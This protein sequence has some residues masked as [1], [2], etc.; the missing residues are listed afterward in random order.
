MLEDRLIE[1]DEELRAIGDV[2]ATGRSGSGAVVSIAGPAGIGKTRLLNAL[3]A[4]AVAGGFRVHRARAAELE[5]DLSRV[6]ISR[7]PVS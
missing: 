1:R 7:T 5:S 4:R 6:K 2:L 3:A